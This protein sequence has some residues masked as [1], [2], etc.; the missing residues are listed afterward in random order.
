MIMSAKPFEEIQLGDT[1]ELRRTITREDVE[2]FVALSGDNNPLHTDLDFASR[3]DLKEPVVHGMM[4][5]NLISALIGKS[6]P[7]PGA[8]WLTQELKFISP[9]RIGDSLVISARVVTKH[10]R[11]QI[12]DLEFN[13]RV[14]GRGEILR[15]RGS[16][17]LLHLSK[18]TEASREKPVR[19]AL[20]TGAS[21][22]IGKAIA[23]ALAADGFQIL[24]QY[25]LN[26]KAAR[27]LQAKLH[28]MDCVCDLVQ[29]N[30]EDEDETSRKVQDAIGRFGHIDTFIATAAATV[31]EA[32]LLRASTHEINRAFRLQFHANR[33]LIC[34]LAPEMLKQR[35][36][37]IIGIS[38]D[39]AHSVPPRG[40][41]SYILGKSAL[42]V[43]IRQCAVEFGPSGVTANI[44]SPGM[45]D[46]GFIINYS[47]RAKQIVAQSAPNRRLGKPSDIA[48]AAA[49]LCGLD[50]DHVNGQTLR[51]N[52]GLGLN[53]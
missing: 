16:V 6:L 9:V 23:A 29:C 8:L 36:G 44:L 39:A 50:A 12:I 41:M 34:L 14:E 52:G 1:S 15:G 20:I 28:E 46:T 24:A 4:T 5:G 18:E 10:K 51:I 2:K 31:Y 17:K 43:L 26:E 30:L 40:W 32:D 53:C 13:A 19:R 7:G 21:G 11:E 25:H 27:T 42:E 3:T 35:W 38:T 49:F 48:S 37:R 22:D 47:P 45:T 33:N